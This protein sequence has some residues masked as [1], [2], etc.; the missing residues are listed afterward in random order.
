MVEIALMNNPFV[1]ALGIPGQSPSHE[2]D[3]KKWCNNQAYSI[4]TEKE[5]EIP[6]KEIPNKKKGNSRMRGIN[7]LMLLNN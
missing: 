6:L 7:C 2:R 1:K 4:K 3:K 5:K